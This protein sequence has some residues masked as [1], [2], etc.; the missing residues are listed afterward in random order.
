MELKFFVHGE[1]VHMGDKVYT[2]E[3]LERPVPHNCI[4]MTHYDR[5]TNQ[6]EMYNPRTEHPVK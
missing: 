1:N 6:W 2:K 4:G 3:N 5:R